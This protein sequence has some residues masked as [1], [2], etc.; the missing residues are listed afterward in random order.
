MENDVDRV[1]WDAVHR[2]GTPC[3]LAELRREALTAALPPG[4]DNTTVW[5]AWPLDTVAEALALDAGETLADVGCGNGDVGRWIGARVGARVIGVDPSAEALAVARHR[6]AES[7]VEAT[8]R[9]GHLRHT[10]LEDE[11]AC[12]VLVVDALHFVSDEGAALAELA[13]ILRP[14]RRLVVV[15]PEL[16]ERPWEAAGLDIVQR[17]ETDGWRE[18]MRLFGSGVEQRY[19]DLVAE[20][21]ERG[22]ADLLSLVSRPLGPE[23]WHGMVVARRRRP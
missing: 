17:T 12:G 14:G 4:I 20:M 2:Q 7:K 15:G 19:A 3:V 22:A 23:A 5:P 16:R 13:R 9:D 11:V 8:Y 10:G 6:A 18:R 21:G 1:R